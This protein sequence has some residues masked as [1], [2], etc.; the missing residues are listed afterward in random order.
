MAA[1]TNP[2]VQEEVG[3][4]SLTR[5]SVAEDDPGKVANVAV[6]PARVLYAASVLPASFDQER[7]PPKDGEGN[8]VNDVI[9]GDVMRHRTLVRGRRVCMVLS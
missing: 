4:G 6:Y 9:Q 7:Q 8:P 1:Q 5:K 2:L 3:T